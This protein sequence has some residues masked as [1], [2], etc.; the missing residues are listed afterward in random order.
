MSQG[1]LGR[2]AIAATQL[3]L[4]AASRALSEEHAAARH[5]AMLARVRSATELSERARRSAME[6][7]ARLGVAR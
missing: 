1:G 4:T 2:R 3:D 5:D 7:V 6:L